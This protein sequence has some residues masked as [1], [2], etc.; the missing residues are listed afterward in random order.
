MKIAAEE[1][2]WPHYRHRHPYRRLRSD[3]RDIHK[4]GERNDRA[5]TAEGAGRNADREREKERN[6]LARHYFSRTPS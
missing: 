2:S 5:T 6:P 3:A 1:A 4:D